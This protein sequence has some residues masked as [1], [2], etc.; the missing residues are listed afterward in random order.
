MKRVRKAIKNARSTSPFAAG[1]APDG[2]I[3]APP[4]S[5]PATKHH[6]K[7]PTGTPAK[8]E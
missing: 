8:T 6:P 4:P 7:K 2:P 5:K 1:A 3:A